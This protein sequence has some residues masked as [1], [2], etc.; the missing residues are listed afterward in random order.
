MIR[1]RENL[2]DLVPKRDKESAK[3]HVPIVIEGRASIIEH[4]PSRKR[5]RNNRLVLLTA[6]GA[7][8]L[9]CALVLYLIAQARHG[10]PHGSG[11]ITTVAQAPAQVG[12]PLATVMTSEYDFKPMVLPYDSERKNYGGLGATIVI[13]LGERCTPIPQN[14]WGHDDLSSLLEEALAKSEVWRPD[15][16]DTIHFGVGCGYFPLVGNEKQKTALVTF[17]GY[18]ILVGHYG[19]EDASGEML[20]KGDACHPTFARMCRENIPVRI[21]V[22]NGD[23]RYYGTLPNHS[24]EKG[25]AHE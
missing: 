16:V 9:V 18:P 19:I 24:C 11:S 7:G 6:I 17:P 22:F 1:F 13:R 10:L 15:P 20:C 3:K 14:L 12:M 8:F 21:V 25:D 23:V 5:H 2:G 4:L